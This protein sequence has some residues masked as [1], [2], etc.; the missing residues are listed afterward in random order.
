MYPVTYNKDITKYSLLSK[1]NSSV[2]TKKQFHLGLPEFMASPAPLYRS[3]QLYNSI[4]CS[5]LIPDFN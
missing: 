2:H 3:S 5:F 4:M 1:Y